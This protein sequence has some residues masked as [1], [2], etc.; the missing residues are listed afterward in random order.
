ML[1]WTDGLKAAALGAAICVT[2]LLISQPA[3]AHAKDRAAAS[4]AASHSGTDHAAAEHAPSD[5]ASAKHAGWSM[6]VVSLHGT[7]EFS[8]GE[9]YGVT[10]HH[11]FAFAKHGGTS[12]AVF[13]TGFAGK[14]VFSK[15]SKA[16]YGGGYAYGYGGISCVPFARAASGIELKGNA[17]NWWDAAAGVYDRGSRPEPGSVLNFRAIGRMRLGHVAVVSSVVNART[18]EVDHANWASG[19]AVS[20]GVTVV[21]VSPRNDWTEVRVALGSS[22][23]MGTG[24]YPTYGFIYDRPDSGTMMA[25][26]GRTAA[27]DSGD[28]EV[29]EAPAHPRHIIRANYKN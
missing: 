15:N 29:A 22:G 6:R 9:G 1:A 17:A 18:I 13:Y 19:G 14:H 27:P 5:H 25:N 28:D 8:G 21:D 20:R 2:P 24:V 11:S 7:V 3:A 16:R 10:S 23:E 12:H 4:H 26:S